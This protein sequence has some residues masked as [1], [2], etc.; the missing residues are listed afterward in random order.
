MF[1]QTIRQLEDS[2]LRLYLV[3]AVKS[4]HVDKAVDF[5]KLLISFFARFVLFPCVR[6]IVSF[7]LTPFLR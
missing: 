1:A 6:C 2:W 4:G 5:F 7:P 3:N